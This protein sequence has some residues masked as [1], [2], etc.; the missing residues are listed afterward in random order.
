METKRFIYQVMLT[1]E[2]EAFDEDDAA[3]AIEDCFGEGD[4]C[5]VEV[6]AVEVLDFEELR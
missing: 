1:L 3:K 4:F 2:I 6:Q 5:G